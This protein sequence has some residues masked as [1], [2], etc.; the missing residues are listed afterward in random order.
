MYSELLSCRFN[1]MKLKG[2]QFT[3]DVGHLIWSFK[4]TSWWTNQRLGYTGTAEQPRTQ[5]QGRAWL[6]GW[7]PRC[8][9]SWFG[10]SEPME[11]YNTLIESLVS[12]QIRRSCFR[13]TSFLLFYK[14]L[15]ACS[16]V[17]WLYRIIYFRNVLIFLFVFNF[18]LKTRLDP[19]VNVFISF[20]SQNIDHAPSRNGQRRGTKAAC[21]VSSSQTK[22]NVLPWNLRSRMQSD[23][24]TFS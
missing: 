20:N 22:P 17:F 14:H 2:K 15:F 5:T 1:L 12:F 24:M 8:L 19:C 4:P 6:R 18:L 10:F 7:R 16:S 21:A 23:K 11:I 9:R 13:D 3:K